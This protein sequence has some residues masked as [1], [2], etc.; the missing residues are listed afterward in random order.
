MTRSRS[1]HD[2]LNGTIPFLSMTNIPLYTCY[3]IFFV[4]NVT[5]FGDGVF[6]G[7][8]LKMRLL[9]WPLIHSDWCLDKMRFWI[10]VHL[11]HT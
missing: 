4:Q 9:G 5:I 8:T 2:S 1:I 3:H 11:T 10:H 7:M 6:K